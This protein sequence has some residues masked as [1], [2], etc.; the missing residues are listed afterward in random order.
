[1]IKFTKIIHFAEGI[2]LIEV[3]VGVLIAVIFAG[4][5]LALI[6]PVRHFAKIR[7]MVRANHVDAILDVISRKSS[8]NN[9]EFEK[10]CNFSPIL[11]IAAKIG[12]GVGEY[13]IA[14]CLVPNY[15]TTFPFDPSEKRANFKG[16]DDYD[17]GYTILR[18]KV[19]G[20]IVITAPSAEL[21]VSILANR[22]P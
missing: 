11:D 13:D 7:N 10:S 17:S 19:T 15:L 14:S 5:G 21:G 8:D 20:N 12:S 18:D 9:G 6:N 16:I 2:A 22:L 4:L 3:A 1:M